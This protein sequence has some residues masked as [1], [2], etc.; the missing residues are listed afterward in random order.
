[1]IL[2]DSSYWQGLLDWIK[3]DVEASG[4]ISEGEMDIF[5]VIDDPE[6]VVKVIKDFYENEGA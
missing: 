5:K 2:V 6:D 1:V 4:R 3:K